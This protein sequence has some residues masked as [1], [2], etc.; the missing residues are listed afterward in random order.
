MVSAR[1]QPVLLIGANKLEGSTV[2]LAK[3]F[4]IMDKRRRAGATEDAMDV[5]GTHGRSG[6]LAISG[7]RT[8]GVPCC[9]VAGGSLDEESAAKEE[10]ETEYQVVGMIKQ[11]LVFNQRPKPIVSKRFLPPSR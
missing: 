10:E 2:K 8:S 7:R 4:L 3:P 6:P 9:L 11:K 5:E 1:V